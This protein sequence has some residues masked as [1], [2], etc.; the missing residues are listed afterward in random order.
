MQKHFLSKVP[1]EKKDGI[2]GFLIDHQIWQNFN[3]LKIHQI[4]HTW[5]YLGN[6][7]I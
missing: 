2:L 5:Y 7:K 3:S 6:P 4:L 1:E